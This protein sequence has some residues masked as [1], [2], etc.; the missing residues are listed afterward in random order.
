MR[1]ALRPL[2][3]LALTLGLSA[4]GFH[5]DTSAPLAQ[6]ATQTEHTPE[7]LSACVTA[8]G[9]QSHLVSLSDIAAANGGNR[10]A[11][12]TGFNA[13]LD[14][15]RKVFQDA[16]YAVTLQPFSVRSF[17]LLSPGVL[18]QR[19]PSPE[20]IESEVFLHSG[21]GDVTALVD[22]PSVPTGCLLQDFAGFVPGRLALI[23]R[24][25][26]SFPEKAQ[27]AEQAGASGVVIFN[28]V[29]GPLLGALS[30]SSSLTLPVVAITQ[31][32]GL[33]LA[34]LIPQGLS[35][36]VKA[37]VRRELVTTYNLLAESRTGRDDAVILVGA[38]LDSA[39]EGPG[40]NDNGSGVAAVL[41]T[42][43]QM[44]RVQPLNKVRFALWGAEETGLEGSTH[45]VQTL[46]TAERLR[47]ALYLNFDMLASSNAGYFI[48][49]GDGS[50]SPDG[51]AGAPG[52]AAIED[53][54]T[55]YYRHRGV[56][57]KPIAMHA[58]SDHW[59]FF[60]AGVPVGGV[61]AGA[62]ALKTLEE[63]TQWGGTANQ[64]FDSCYH[65]PC[66]DLSN[67][68]LQALGLNA[69]AVA[70]ATLSLASQPWTFEK[71]A[72]QRQARSVSPAKVP[73]VAPVRAK[74]R[75]PWHTTH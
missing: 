7:T 73:A 31:E 2:L 62:Y 55:R 4:C 42:A 39:E 9:V 52:A 61:D 26:C 3:A 64:P 65:E 13:A 38:H 25:D 24:G 14:Y 36:R 60:A 8:E 46:P 6:C 50:M 63:A 69:G 44:A 27:N 10:A 47:L 41:E 33:R 28:N 20:V 23:Q 32:A 58:Y 29:E 75:S 34:A 68:N 51:M 17:A 22:M 54:F 11:G 30:T 53:T 35:L 12:T 19:S 40:I 59:P 5:D 18:E 74:L 15:A 45:Y 72:I 43:R 37:D 16:G 48:L 71:T 66:D 21:R 70:W 57:P 56:D 49:D 67:L 1:T